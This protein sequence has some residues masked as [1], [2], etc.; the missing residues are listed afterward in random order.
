M[1][2][3]LVGLV[4][5]GAHTHHSDWSDMVLHNTASCGYSFYGSQ[6]YWGRDWQKGTHI[7]YCNLTKVQNNKIIAI[8]LFTNIDAITNINFH[9]DYF[10]WAVGEGRIFISLL[11]IEKLDFYSY[12]LSLQIASKCIFTHPI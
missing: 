5:M 7:L 12:F 1:L 2:E 10:L 9:N 4:E 6:C 11:L 8:D 3:H